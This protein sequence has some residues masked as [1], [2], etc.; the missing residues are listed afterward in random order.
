[1]VSYQGYLVKN[2]LA[3]FSKIPSRGRAEV[4]KSGGAGQVLLTAPCQGVFLMHRLEPA[5][6]HI[7]VGA[8]ARA[9][10]PQLD[11]HLAVANAINKAAGDDLAAD[12]QRVEG[13]GLA[14]FGRLNH[15]EVRHLLN[16]ARDQRCLV[17]CDQGLAIMLDNKL[18]TA[19]G[20]AVTD[21][22]R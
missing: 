18:I 9:L 20:Q 17:P 19:F 7:R 21:T 10:A 22:N 16:N 6:N 14:L 1:M 12:G 3:D 2:S 13:H 15:C 11:P 8:E 4:P 5:C